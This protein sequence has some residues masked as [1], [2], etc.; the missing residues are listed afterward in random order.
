MFWYLHYIKLA[1]YSVWNAKLG[2]RNANFLD[3]RWQNSSL[4]LLFGDN[5][6]N[7]RKRRFRINACTNW[8]HIHFLS[9]KIPPDKHKLPVFRGIKQPTAGDKPHAVLRP[10]VPH[11][12]RSPDKT[13]VF[14]HLEWKGPIAASRTGLCPTVFFYFN[15]ASRA[16]T[17]LHPSPWRSCLTAHCLLSFPQSPFLEHTVL[18]R[19]QMWSCTV[20]ID[21]GT[22]PPH[23]TGQWIAVVD[24]KII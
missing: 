6:R 12:Q 11:V 18:Y 16:P 23:P 24:R 2:P 15:A 13:R 21:F 4:L 9:Y 22:A 17:S 8:I 5:S 3:A 7:W 10:S 19:T 1:S 20:P 14:A